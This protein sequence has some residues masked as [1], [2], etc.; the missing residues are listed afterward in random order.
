[1]L[2][3]RHANGHLLTIRTNGRLSGVRRGSTSPLA[4]WSFPSYN[5]AVPA[6]Q[7]VLRSVTAS[8]DTSF[9]VT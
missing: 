7:V 3:F 5:V 9:T 4:G 8:L 6:Y 1:V 2:V